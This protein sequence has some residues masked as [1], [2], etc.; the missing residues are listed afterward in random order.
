MLG[1]GSTLYAHG[2]KLG[3]S[4]DKPSGRLDRVLFLRLFFKTCG[5]GA[6]GLV[7]S[8]VHSLDDQSPRFPNGKAGKMSTPG[9][10]SALCSGASKRWWRGNPMAETL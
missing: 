6:R 2:L 9:D 8:L 10:P 4:P 1:P 3:P 5:Q 7:H